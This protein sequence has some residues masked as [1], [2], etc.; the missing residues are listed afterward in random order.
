MNYDDIHLVVTPLLPGE[1]QEPGVEVS[2][3]TV[4]HLIRYQSF[5]PDTLKIDVEGYEVNVL[6]GASDLL[7]IT[8]P[9]VFLEVHPHLLGRVGRSVDEL[10]RLMEAAGYGFADGR[11]SRSRTRELTLG[12]VFAEWS[13]GR[14]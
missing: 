10:V 12:E 1:C 14:R 6:E 5:Q 8:G 9:L 3:I 2:A 7:R 13:A 11:E 4:D